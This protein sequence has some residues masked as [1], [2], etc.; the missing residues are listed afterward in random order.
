MLLSNHYQNVRQC[1]ADLVVCIDVEL[2]TFKQ[3]KQRRRANFKTFQMVETSHRMGA[4]VFF[5]G[6]N[7]RKGTDDIS[8][9]HLSQ[10]I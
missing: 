2:A 1:N 5:L 6:L 7:R 3:R 8:T 4:T 9:L 10:A